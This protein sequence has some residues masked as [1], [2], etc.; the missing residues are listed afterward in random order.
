MSLPTVILL[1]VLLAGVLAAMRYLGKYRE[2]KEGT[3]EAVELCG[4][5][6]SAC[7]GGEYCHVHRHLKAERNLPAYFED[8][9][10]DRYRG[11]KPEDF[12]DDEAREWEEVLTTLRPKE[13]V[14]WV[15][16]IHRRGLHIPAQLRPQLKS[17]LSM[18]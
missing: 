17:A 5:T 6:G 7:Y 8:E 12:S 9:E 13:V 15:G 11:R 4:V 16:S 18:D 1:A 2:E 10:L 14:E 3:P